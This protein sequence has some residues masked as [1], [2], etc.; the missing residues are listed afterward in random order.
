MTIRARIHLA[1]L[2]LAHATRELAAV[3]REAR[4]YASPPTKVQARVRLAREALAAAKNP[5]PKGAP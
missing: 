4:A 3:E 2:A 5:P 1:P